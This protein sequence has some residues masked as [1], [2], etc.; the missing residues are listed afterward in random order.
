MVGW[1]ILPGAV[2]VPVQEFFYDKKYQNSNYDQRA[3]VYFVCGVFKCFRDKMDESVPQKRADGQ[4]NENKNIFAQNI[5][6]QRKR[7][8]PDQRDQAYH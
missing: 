3:C 4:R 2:M 6:A 8:D 7:E 5:L 1:L